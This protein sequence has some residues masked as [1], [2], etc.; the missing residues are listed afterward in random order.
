MANFA[1]LTQASSGKLI[2]LNL[3]MV[4]YFHETIESTEIVFSESLKV[5]VLESEGLILQLIKEAD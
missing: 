1:M 3:D 2:R 5:S 4:A